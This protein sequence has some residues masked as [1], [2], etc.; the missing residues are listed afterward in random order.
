MDTDEATRQI[1]YTLSE[2]A[3][4]IDFDEQFVLDEVAAGRIKA[5][6]SGESLRIT[7]GALLDWVEYW[8]SQP[9]D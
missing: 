1:S 4:Q 8:R 7:R 5:T 3:V 6:G 2:A 9:Q